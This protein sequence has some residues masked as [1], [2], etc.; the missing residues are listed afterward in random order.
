MQF[1]SISS[2]RGVPHGAQRD[3]LL[4][5]KKKERREA[6]REHLLP[7]QKCNLKVLKVRAFKKTATGLLV[8]GIIKIRLSV[9]VKQKKKI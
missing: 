3:I 5:Q 4:V 9:T 2:P 6:E 8:A 7:Q 1:N